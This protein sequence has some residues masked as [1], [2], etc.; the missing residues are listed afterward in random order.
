M[1]RRI[2]NSRQTQK[3][4]RRQQSKRR[5]NNLRK[6]RKNTRKN[7]RAASSKKN[8]KTYKKGGAGLLQDCNPDRTCEGCPDELKQACEMKKKADEL[9]VLRQRTPKQIAEKK[10]G[11]T[12][13][14]ANKYEKQDKE[15]IRKR[16]GSHP[17]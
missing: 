12:I 10:R 7:L 9:L 17:F 5:G 3:R 15:W 16:Q 2:R 4:R 6:T 8:R 1:A 13:M 14:Q 11:N